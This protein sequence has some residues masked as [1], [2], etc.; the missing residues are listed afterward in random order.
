[1]LKEMSKIFSALG[2]PEQQFEGGET[3]NTTLK[4]AV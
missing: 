3:L 2:P 1:M 4:A